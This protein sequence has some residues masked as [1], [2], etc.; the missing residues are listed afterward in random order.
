M[1][2]S[3]VTRLLLADGGW[4]HM[5][6]WAGGWMVVGWLAMIAVIALVAVAIWRAPTAAPGR[7]VSRAQQILA[8]RFARGEISKAE[9]D[10]ARSA[11]DQ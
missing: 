7:G 10:E 4:D 3:I 8:E 2:T 6:G 11:I 9:Y 1:T 5:S